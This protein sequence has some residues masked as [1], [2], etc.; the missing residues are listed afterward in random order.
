MQL[1]QAEHPFSYIDITVEGLKV[2]LNGLDEPAV[3][4]YRYVVSVKR[5][6]ER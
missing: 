5:R 4:R 3:D 2:G 6:F 1:F